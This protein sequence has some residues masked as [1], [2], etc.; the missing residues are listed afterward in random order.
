MASGKLKVSGIETIEITDPQGLCHKVSGIET[1][2]ITDPQGLCQDKAKL[3][4]LKHI[5]AGLGP[6]VVDPDP[7]KTWKTHY[8]P[9]Q[10]PYTVEPGGNVTVEPGWNPV[11]TIFL[12]NPTGEAQKGA[13]IIDEA[14]NLSCDN[15]KL[16]VMYRDASNVL[17]SVTSTQWGVGLKGARN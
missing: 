17:R 6:L 2:E 8:S 4:I 7:G 16:Q 13:V 11:K 15:P 12:T 9:V 10:L 14:G 1:I 3:D 5:G